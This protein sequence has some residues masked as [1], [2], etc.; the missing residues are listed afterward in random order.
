MD[1]TKEYK[2]NFDS[3]GK[4]FIYRGYL[5]SEDNEFIVFKDCMLGEIQLNRHKIISMIPIN[6]GGF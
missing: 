1:K 5:I 3:N 2:I 6:G 4:L